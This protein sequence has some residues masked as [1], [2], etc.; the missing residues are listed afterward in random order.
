MIDGVWVGRVGVGVVVGIT[1]NEGLVVGVSAFEDGAVG[2]GSSDELGVSPS[3]GDVP[4]VVNPSGGGVDAGGVSVSRK[5]SE[6]KMSSP[7]PSPAPS[8]AGSL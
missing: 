5:V 8:P 3:P 6:V 7:A 2:S 4:G 1:S